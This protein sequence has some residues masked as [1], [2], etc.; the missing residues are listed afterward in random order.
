MALRLAKKIM[1]AQSAI[2]TISTI[3]SGADLA[4]IRELTIIAEFSSGVSAGAIQLA[5]AARPEYAGVW[6]PVGAPLGFV[7]GGSKHVSN[8]GINGAAKV[9]ISTGI[10]GGTV[11]V[12][13]FGEG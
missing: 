12:W 13:A 3:L 2:N 7:D 10:V 8:T 4:G 9:T 5:V 1:D 6:S 11:D